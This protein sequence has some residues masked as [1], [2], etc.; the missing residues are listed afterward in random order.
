MIFLV[1]ETFLV[2][3]VL[4]ASGKRDLSRHTGWV[5]VFKVADILP[6]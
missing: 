3:A 1:A 4:A 2:L 6:E 5:V